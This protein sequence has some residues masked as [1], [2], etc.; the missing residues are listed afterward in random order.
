MALRARGSRCFTA[1]PRHDISGVTTARDSA[2]GDEKSVGKR[3]CGNAKTAGFLRFAC[4]SCPVAEVSATRGGVAFS[5]PYVAWPVLVPSP[6]VF[7]SHGVWPRVHR[8]SGGEV[9]W[10]DAISTP[11]MNS[12]QSPAWINKRLLT[13]LPVFFDSGRSVRIQ[14]FFSRSLV[15]PCGR[16]S[17]CRR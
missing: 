1:S 9:K 14:G 13:G 17:S 5:P 12:R 7:P 11:R 4:E 6:C 2:T 15:R 16:G 3:K 8:P 10:V